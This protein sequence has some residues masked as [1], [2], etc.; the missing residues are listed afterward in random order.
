MANPKPA[1]SGAPESALVLANPRTYDPR[2]WVRVYDNTT[3]T[4]LPHPVPETWLDGRFPQLS[5]TPSLK[6]AGK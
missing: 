1:D 5:Q 3:G 2:K 4:K 6:K